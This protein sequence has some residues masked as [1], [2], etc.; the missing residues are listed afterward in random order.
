MLSTKGKPGPVMDRIETM[1]SFVEVAKH[2]SFSVAAR[3]LKISRALVS[4]HIQDLEQSLGIRLLNRT[5]RSVTLTEAG[6]RYFAFCNRMLEEMSLEEKALRRTQDEPEG[7]LKVVAPMWFGSLD[8]GGVIADFITLHPRIAVNLVLGGLGSR[9][10]RFL[11]EGFDVAIHTRKLPDSRLI[12]RRLGSISWTL[13]A[14]PAYLDKAQK[15]QSLDELKHHACLAHAL[16][17]PWRFRNGSRTVIVKTDAILTCNN[18]LPLRMA[19]LRG[20]GI[21]MLPSSMVEEDLKAGRLSPL[22]PQYPPL[23]RPLHVA[24]SPGGKLPAKADLFV[25]YLVQ[26]FRSAPL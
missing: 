10:F 3:Q 14:S 19:A 1:G 7:V 21:T 9:T 11:D 25:K 12:A 13:C 18:Y 26:R 5:T 2:G 16:N 4:R 8:I 15:V 22:L 20:L 17:T 6:S 23:L 24:Y